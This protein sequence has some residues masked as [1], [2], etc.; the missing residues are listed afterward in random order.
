[1]QLTTVRNHNLHI[2]F[3]FTKVS[4]RICQ[5]S[6]HEHWQKILFLLFWVLVL[7]LNPSYRSAAKSEFELHGLYCSIVSTKST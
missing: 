5:C 2:A 7:F 6:L 1:M 4:R 3:C